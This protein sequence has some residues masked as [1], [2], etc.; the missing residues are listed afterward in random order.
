M[1]NLLQVLANVAALQSYNRK[2]SNLTVQQRPHPTEQVLRPAPTTSINRHATR[3]HRGGHHIG[4]ASRWTAIAA[5]MNPGLADAAGRCATE[6][7]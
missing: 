1:Q 7:C 6:G 4:C 2:Y 5:G 3:S